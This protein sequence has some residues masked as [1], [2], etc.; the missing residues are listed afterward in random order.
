MSK[1][2]YFIPIIEQAL[3]G[4][5]LEEG[6]R[7]AFARIIRIGREPGYRHAFVQFQRFMEEVNNGHVLML[8]EEQGDQPVEAL[9]KRFPLH[10][11]I[12]KEEEFFGTY[13]FDRIPDRYSIKNI[14]PG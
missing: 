8:G 3:Q 10:I 7:E 4:E 5:N 6:L 1:N 14:I 13:Q 2:L 11:L 9:L 12:E